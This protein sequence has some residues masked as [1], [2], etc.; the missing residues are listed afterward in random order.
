M[1]S[2]TEQ[3]APARRV[4]NA[5]GLLLMGLGMFLFA[6]V[7][8]AAKLLT[9]D[10][11][12]MQI[13]WTRQLGLLA[14]ALV[15]LGLHGPKLFRTTHLNLQI[16]RGVAAACS[17]T[18]FIF[19][20]RHVALAD[21][22]AISFVAPFM[23]TLMGALI[24]RE[25]V[26]IRRWIAVVLGFI[27]TLI[28]LRPGVGVIHP[29]AGLVIMAA[30]FFACRQIISRATSDTDKTGTTIVYTALVGSAVLSLPLPWIWVTPEPWA[31]ALLIGMAALA[32]A[33]EILVIK[34]LEV[35]MA[36]VITPIHYTLILWGTFYGWL[37]F[38]ELPD[39]WTWVGAAI[40]VATGLYT[41]RREYLVSRA[42]REGR[43][44]PA[45]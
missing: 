30:F 4:Q 8:A 16:A 24:L 5:A 29:A 12:P 35:G 43:I 14:V 25:P 27:G 17:A 3:T 15:L 19:A 1:T 10:L 22:V 18:L 2:V 44:T 34:A 13:V 33:G 38:N 31:I 21:A 32:A 39:L 6:A 28:I 7:D 42:R 23:V 36:V 45:A 40:I 11:H 41:L 9:A 26:G 37:I 20:L